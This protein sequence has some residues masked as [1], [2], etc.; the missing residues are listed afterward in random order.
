MADDLA[1][2]VDVAVLSYD[3]SSGDL[4]ADSSPCERLISDQGVLSDEVVLVHLYGEA[5]AR[6]LWG[7]CVVHVVSVERHGG[8]HSKGVSCAQSARE[9]AELLAGL[10]DHLPQSRSVLSCGV[11][12]ESVLAGVSGPGYHAVD[13]SDLAVEDSR[14]VHLRNGLRCGD[15]R[16]DLRGL[17]PLESQLAPV[18]AVVH[19]LHI[20]VLR[21]VAAHP[22]VVL[23]GVCGVYDH[24]VIVV[25][26]LVDDQIVYG[27]AVLVAHRAVARLPVLHV[28]EVVGQH[29]VQVLQAVR[30]GYQDLSHVGNIEEACGSANRHVFL[31]DACLVLYRK[32]E[33]PERYH[34]SAVFD[35]SFVEWC[36]LFHFHASV[37]RLEI[38]W[39]FTTGGIDRQRA[40]TAGN[41]L[42]IMCFQLSS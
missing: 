11:D 14:V 5:Q 40:V 24:E 7:N 25:S 9:D 1:V 23:L 29:I 33:S 6:S 13:V 21:N 20:A 32:D 4:D 37:V 34:L 22:V 8:F 39:D 3:T 2:S 19:Q 15:L 42:F 38:H 26:P 18:V 10:E 31:L 35:M 12:L 30:A 41:P 28:G 36:F 27:T 17:R 16:Q